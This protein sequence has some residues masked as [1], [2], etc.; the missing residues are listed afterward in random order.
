M[1][2]QPRDESYI[3]SSGLKYAQINQTK[4]PREKYFRPEEKDGSICH[5]LLRRSHIF[6]QGYFKNFTDN[7]QT[8]EK[9][10]RL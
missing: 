2:F 10:L 1:G 4:Q 6:K 5:L 9:W 3:L 8:R 7:I